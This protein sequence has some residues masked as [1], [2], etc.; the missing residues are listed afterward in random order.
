MRYYIACVTIVRTLVY[1]S[2]HREVR[3]GGWGSEGPKGL[4][5][6]QYVRV[7][8]YNEI[9]KRK[10]ILRFE[11]R[12]FFLEIGLS[13]WYINFTFIGRGGRVWQKTGT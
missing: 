2:F 3:L 10:Y 5:L 7:E 6:G 1:C 13:H 12:Y 11:I 9:R 8:V 4:T